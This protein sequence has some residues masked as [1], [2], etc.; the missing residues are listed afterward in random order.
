MTG[1]VSAP[2]RRA[3][4]SPGSRTGLG[5]SGVPASGDAKAGFAMIWP[6]LSVCCRKVLI[7]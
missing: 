4:L 7:S 3:C 2:W 5:L 6:L 1:A